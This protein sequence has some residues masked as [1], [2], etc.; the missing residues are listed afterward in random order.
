HWVP[1]KI[2]ELGNLEVLPEQQK[3]FINIIK[4]EWLAQPIKKDGIWGL[5]MHPW[6]QEE[7]FRYQRFTPEEPS[8]LTEVPRLL[9]SLVQLFPEVNRYSH[10]NW[11]QAKLYYP[12][13]ISLLEHVKTEQPSLEQGLLLYRLGI[14]HR[15]ILSDFEGAQNYFQRASEIYKNIPD[16]KIHEVDALIELGQ[17][18]KAHQGHHLW[19]SELVKIMNESESVDETLCSVENTTEVFKEDD[20]PCLYF[21]QSLGVINQLSSSAEDRARKLRALTLVCNC[22]LD[23]GNFEMARLLFVEI[24]QR[25]V[26]LTECKHEI[27]LAHALQTF[28]RMSYYSKHYLQAIAHFTNVQNLYAKLYPDANL[29]EVADGFVYMGCVVYLNPDASLQYTSEQAFGSAYVIYQKN[30]LAGRDRSL[31]KT[32]FPLYSAIINLGNLT[33]AQKLALKIQALEQEITVQENSNYPDLAVAS[34]LLAQSLNRYNPCNPKAIEYFERGLNISEAL[35][36]TVN[37]TLVADAYQ[38]LADCYE[39]QVGGSVMKSLLEVPPISW[40]LNW[41]AGRFQLWSDMQQSL[42]KL[43]LLR[44]SS[45]DL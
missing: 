43:N 2:F 39:G 20:L 25:I 7:M 19:R 35:G 42:N 21:N 17:T 24:N 23:Y 18:L 26:D 36:G 14:Y 5:Q 31:M 8:F 40:V 12:H 38:E 16:A 44:I 11:S 3:A 13:V 9:K 34:I 32:S 30:G 45:D 33:A 22:Y 4:S 27:I 6:T 28:G 15:E 1:L 29:T 10:D 41:F 37:N